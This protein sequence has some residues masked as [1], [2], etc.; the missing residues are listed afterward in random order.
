MKKQNSSHDSFPTRNGQPGFTITTTRNWRCHQTVNS[1]FGLVFFLFFCHWNEFSFVPRFFDSIALQPE[2][3]NRVI[4]LYFC[5]VLFRDC[6]W[7][8]RIRIDFSPARHATTF[9]AAGAKF[10]LAN[11]NLVKSPENF[12]PKK[13]KEKQNFI[14]FFFI[15]N[16]ASP[17]FSSPLFSIWADWYAG[18]CLSLARCNNVF[19][20][21]PFA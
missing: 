12:R 17:L 9:L 20:V 18:Q 2:R 4:L 3:L 1:L 21:L 8:L 16:K 5:F 13:K 19:P 6:A 7:S 10:L 15:L 14:F 11:K